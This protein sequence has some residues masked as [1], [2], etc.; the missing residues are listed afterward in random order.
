[1]PLHTATFHPFWFLTPFLSMVADMVHSLLK[2]VCFLLWPRCRQIEASRLL[3]CTE[4]DDCCHRF[5]LIS[6]SFFYSGVS[7]R[8]LHLTNTI[9]LSLLQSVGCVPI[10]S[11]AEISPQPYAA[12]YTC[13]HSNVY[14]TSPIRTWRVSKDFATHDTNIFLVCKY[15]SM[16]PRHL[17]WMLYRP[18]TQM[19]DSKFQAVYRNCCQSNNNCVQMCS[20]SELT[21]DTVKKTFP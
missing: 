13:E 12:M 14:Q 1:M 18:P 8:R 11:V 20:I 5:F 3:N 2:S 7:I 21:V 19:N 15:R 16:D 6:T 9:A 10:G 17:K 4:L